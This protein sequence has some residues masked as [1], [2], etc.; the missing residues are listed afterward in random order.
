[1]PKKKPGR[2]WTWAPSKMQK[3]TVPEKIKA[4]LEAKAAK[5]VEAVLTPKYIKPPP[6]VQRF[7]YP[8]TI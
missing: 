6:K 7:N 1:M 2:Q 5:L 4:D 8:T 3:P